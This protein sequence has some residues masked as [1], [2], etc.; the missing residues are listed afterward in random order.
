MRIIIILSLV[1]GLFAGELEVEGNLT[2]TGDIDSPTIDALRD[3][4]N[5]EYT[6]FFVQI[7]TSNPIR[8]KLSLNKLKTAVL[9]KLVICCTS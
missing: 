5:Y 8:V 1:T 3:D 9:S 7:T 4:G 2:V 6:I